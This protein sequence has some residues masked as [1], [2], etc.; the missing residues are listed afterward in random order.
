MCSIFEFIFIYC[1]KINGHAG[2]ALAGHLTRIKP[3]FNQKFIAMRKVLTAA[4]IVFYFSL[5]GCATTK[6]VVQQDLPDNT[7]L[8]ENGYR[9]LEQKLIEE[10][11]AYAN[12]DGVQQEEDGVVI[13]NTRDELEYQGKAQDTDARVLIIRCDFLIDMNNMQI[14]RISK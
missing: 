10:Y 13:Y 7:P 11:L 1:T 8:A 2:T 12:F 5:V 14:Y 3:I 4:L 6:Q 9:V